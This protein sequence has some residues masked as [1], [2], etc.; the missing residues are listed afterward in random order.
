MDVAVFDTS[1]A[2]KDGS[3]AGDPDG[4]TLDNRGTGLAE[5]H[6]FDSKVPADVK[7]D[8]ETIKGDIASGKIKITSAAQPK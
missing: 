6:D 5:F 8:L 1:E 3:V 7:A 4:G 2:A